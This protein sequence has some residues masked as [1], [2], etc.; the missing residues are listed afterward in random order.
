MSSDLWSFALAVYARCGVED[1][2]LHLQSAGANVCLMLCGL[3]L[4]QRGVS[5]EEERLRELE[6]L[7]APW[8]R[9]VVQPLRELR[10]QWKTRTE[11]DA[12]LKGMREQ[13][14]GLE[15]EAERALLSRLEGVAQGWARNS[16]DQAVWLEGLAGTAAHLNRDA[17]QVLRVAAI[18]T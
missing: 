14:K 18:G 17:L 7:T 2:C 6:Q 4:E 12:V 16:A 10:M 11:T 15:L 9:E 1:A 3:W 8:D 5:C 13:V